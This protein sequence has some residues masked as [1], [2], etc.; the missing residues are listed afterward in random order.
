M[1]HKG[2]KRNGNK[3]NEVVM[4]SGI[5]ARHAHKRRHRFWA[6]LWLH[7]GEL[8]LDG[9]LDHNHAARNKREK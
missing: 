6:L 9:E 3:T 1:K 2:A 7:C 8:L 4:R 5:L